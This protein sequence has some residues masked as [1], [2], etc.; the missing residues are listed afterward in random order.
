MVSFDVDVRGG[1]RLLCRDGMT[2]KVVKDF[3]TVGAGRLAEGVPSVSGVYSVRVFSESPDAA[4]ARI[5]VVKR[6][7]IA[8]AVRRRM[9]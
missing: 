7:G 6:Y 4:N 3:K 8:P 1:E 2:W 5:N 9:Q